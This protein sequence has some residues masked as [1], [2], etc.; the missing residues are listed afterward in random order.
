MED[1]WTRYV[2][3]K[4]TGCTYLFDYY[5][6]AEKCG[7]LPFGIIIKLDCGNLVKNRILIVDNPDPKINDK[8]VS[9]NSFNFELVEE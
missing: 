4:T 8:C 3:V 7:V 6:A 9:L 1:S 2:T 5:G